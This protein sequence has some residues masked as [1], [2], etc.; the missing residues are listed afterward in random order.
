M[1]RNA[2]HS[3]AGAVAAE[4]SA[5][6]RQRNSRSLAVLGMTTALGM[7]SAPQRQLARLLGMTTAHG[8]TPGCGERRRRDERYG[9]FNAAARL[10]GEIDDA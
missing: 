1:T 10:V 4:E 7:T 2:C 6:R 8:M 9:C 3:E 5:V